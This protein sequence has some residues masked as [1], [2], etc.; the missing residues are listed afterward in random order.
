[1]DWKDFFKPTIGKIILLIVLFFLS[2]IIWDWIT[3]VMSGGSSDIG[4]PF[5]FL[6][7]V[8]WYRGGGPPVSRTIFSLPLLIVDIIIWYLVSCGIV[9]L[10]KKYK[11]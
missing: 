7:F 9:A 11:K 6:S 4:F 8:Q 5:S 1:M 10:Y 3:P 2:T